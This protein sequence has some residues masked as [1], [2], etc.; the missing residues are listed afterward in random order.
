MIHLLL[1]CKILYDL[2]PGNISDFAAYLSLPPPLC[3]HHA[4][5]VSGHLRAFALLSPQSGVLSQ[6][7]V[8]L[9][10]CHSV[11]SYQLKPAFSDYPSKIT[12]THLWNYPD[13][14]YCPYLNVYSMIT[15]T[16]SFSESRNEHGTK[17][18]YNTY[19]L[20]DK[21]NFNLLKRPLH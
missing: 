14:F 17:Q 1:T 4:S 9:A 16:L 7:T 13:I 11:P 5:L 15:S 8:R 3:S 21:T 12:P 10:P 2:A 19:L 6:I 20:T 18:V